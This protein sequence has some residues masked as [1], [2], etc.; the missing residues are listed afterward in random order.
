[1]PRPGTS[2]NVKRKIWELGEN[3][4]RASAAWI[5]KTLLTR[6]EINLPT[7][8][9]IARIKKD[10]LSKQPQERLP[11]RYASWPEAMESNAL[12]WESSRALL[13]LLRF[14]EESGRGRPIIQVAEWFWRVSLAAPEL[15]VAKRYDAAKR[16]LM[17][18][19][20]IAPPPEA[21]RG[22]EW[23][24]V[25]EPWLSKGNASAYKRAQSKTPGGVP[26]YRLPPLKIPSEDGIVLAGD[27]IPE[28]R[29]AIQRTR[30]E[31]KK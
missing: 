31:R 3:N 26:A 14:F 7:E 23:F 6:G 12:P 19:S 18:R 21:P 1:M 29:A 15:D 25:F 16:L 8:R 24:L 9:T 4:P 30:K 17:I 11:Y 5:R 2:D 13:D 20:A 28:V 27:L 22:V 10:F